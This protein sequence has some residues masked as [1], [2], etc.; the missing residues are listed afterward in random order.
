PAHAAEDV[1]QELPLRSQLDL[2][3]V[4]AAQLLGVESHERDVAVWKDVIGIG[5]TQ[6]ELV[7]WRRVAARGSDGHAGPER[8]CEIDRQVPPDVGEV[9][10]EVAPPVGESVPPP[11]EGLESHAATRE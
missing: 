8:D 3:D 6:K 11:G 1:A 2:L 7:V 10:R 9:V 4:P 5:A